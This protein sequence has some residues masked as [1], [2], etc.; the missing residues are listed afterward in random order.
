MKP[1][2]KAP[3]FQ[4]KIE[5]YFQECERDG[6]YP[7]E[8]GLILH[9]KLDKETYDRYKNNA[10]GTPAGYMRYLEDA[11][12]RRESIIVRDIYSNEKSPTGKIFLARQPE[13]GGLCDK[14]PQTS[15]KTTVEVLIDG[16][17]VNHFE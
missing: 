11:R 8:A 15:A 4:K 3:A 9:L 6:I 2:K 12:L 13:N 1:D 7:D 14:A 17:P 16:K 10:K 5:D